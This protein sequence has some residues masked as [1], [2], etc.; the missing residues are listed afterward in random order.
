[1]AIAPGTI[2]KCTELSDDGYKLVAVI[3]HVNDFAAY[4]SYLDAST[5]E[6]AAVGNKISS[7]QA[8]RKFPELTSYS[9]RR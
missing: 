1:M 6:C 8:R 4:E 2:I 7:E 5:E 9:Y 3:G